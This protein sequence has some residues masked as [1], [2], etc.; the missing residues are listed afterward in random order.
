MELSQEKLMNLVALI[1]GFI[2][3]TCADPEGGGGQEV[4]TPM[5]N[6]KNIGFLSN[7]GQNPL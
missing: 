4:Q 3:T 6:H 7:T 2:C 5:K 1:Y